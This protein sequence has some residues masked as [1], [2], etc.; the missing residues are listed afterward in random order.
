MK[1]SFT[2]SLR[3]FWSYMWQ[4]N[5]QTKRLLKLDFSG[6]MQASTEKM[7]VKEQEVANHI[8]PQGLKMGSN[9]EPPS[10][11][12]GNGT[13]STIQKAG[14]FVG[15]LAFLL[16]ML[17][18]TPEGM[19][20]EAQAVLAVTTWVSIW[21]ITEPIPIPATSLMP[22][23]LFPLT[24]AMSASASTAG[25]SNPL[26]YVFM[27]GFMIAVAMERWNLHKRIAL[28]IIQIVGTSPNRIILG[29]MVATAFLSMW[30]SNTATAM[31]MMPIGLAVIV[32]VGTLIKEQKLNVDISHGKFKFGTALM[33]GIAYAASIGGV[34]TLIGT[35]P[36]TVFAGVVS[37]MFG[38]EIGFATWMLYGVPISVVFLI[39]TWV[40]LTKIAFPI[41]LKE[42][43]GG[44]EVI[45]NEYKGL[46]KITKPEK[47]VLAVFLF[48]ACSWVLITPIWKGQS[49][50]L[51]KFFPMIHDSTIAILAALLLFLIPVNL[52]KGEFLLN[53][54][55]AVKIPW[56]IILLFGG[57]LSIATGFSSTGLAGWMAEQLTVLEG[58]SIILI[59][60]SVVTLVIFL[61]EIT[62]NTATGTM[63][64]PIMAAMAAAMGIHPYALMITAATAASFAFMLPVATPPNAVVFGTGY[65]SMHQMVKAGFWLNIL[66]IIVI[67][68][69]TTYW[70][71]ISWGID[72]NVLPTWL[73]K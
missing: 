2:V 10:D 31:M 69:M 34:A 72:I 47:L 65:V 33:L 49:F 20:P 12:N 44:K 63:M 54:E 17:M 39:A 45:D 66:G 70:L 21:W 41:E 1:N 53:W 60:L 68:L 64:M 29:F 8:L 11:D 71:P 27:G 40:Y 46:G 61:T 52:K 26:I 35:P 28:R 24:N 51:S 25:Y 15:P 57:G 22:I 36:N 30:I 56:G 67:T 73:N 4:L 16:L 55:T 38:Q 9:N 13:Y 32:Q 58:A 6:V 5:D 14:L 7:S 37:E 43:P 59:M 19:T 50:Y 3:N 48:A 62:S 42:L 18:G 23:F